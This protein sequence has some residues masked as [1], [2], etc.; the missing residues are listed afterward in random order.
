[1][2]FQE[3]T[4][5]EAEIVDIDPCEEHYPGIDEI[6]RYEKLYFTND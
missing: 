2:F 6:T 4:G 1:M 5:Q 3:F